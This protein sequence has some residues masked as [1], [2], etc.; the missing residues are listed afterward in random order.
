[1]QKMQNYKYLL[2][3]L[4]LATAGCADTTFQLL[5]ERQEMRDFAVIKGT[6]SFSVEYFED[7]R[8][9]KVTGDTKR[10][11]LVERTLEAGTKTFV[12]DKVMED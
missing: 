10:P 9:K 5:D 7:G 4:L 3:V 2:G 1:M 12:F 8:L 6:G 11:S